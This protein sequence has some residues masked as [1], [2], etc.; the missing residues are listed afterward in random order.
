MAQHPSPDHAP[1]HVCLVTQVGYLLHDRVIRPA[2]VIV[3]AA[4]PAEADAATIL[5]PQS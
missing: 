4:P 5:D 2:Q 1:G 3:A